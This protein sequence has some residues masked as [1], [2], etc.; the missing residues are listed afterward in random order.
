M[1]PRGNRRQQEKVRKH[2]MSA[3]EFDYVIV[4]AGA[5]GCV[6]A[7]RLSEDPSVSVCLLEAGGPDKSVF[8]HAPLG[9]AAAAP[10]GLNAARYETVPQ[11]QLNGRR[12]FQPRGRVIGGS[13]SVNAMVYTRGQ[14]ADYD[15]WAELG[16][17]GWDY[18]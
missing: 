9:C 1:K 13:T 15:H 17:P 6:L 10:I 12:G 7:G 4:G 16:N 5:G 3:M 8:I 14:G 2:R 18:A 11:A